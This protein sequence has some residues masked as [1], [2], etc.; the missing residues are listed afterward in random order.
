MMA[1]T[2]LFWLQDVVVPTSGL[3]LPLVRVLLLSPLIYFVL[4]GTAVPQD[5][6]NGQSIILIISEYDLGH[7][8]GRRTTVTVRAQ[9]SHTNH[10][11][12][13]CEEEEEET[14]VV[15]VVVVVAVVVIVVIVIV[16]VVVIIT[17]II[18]AAIEVEVVVVVCMN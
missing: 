14:E 16:I 9:Y 8:Y 11:S 15:V 1:T 3:S 6:S 13:L 5:H 2:M 4:L 18:V 17:I 10:V 12:M 7:S